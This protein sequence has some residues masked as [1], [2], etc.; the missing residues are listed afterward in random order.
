MRLDAL[1]AKYVADG[2]AAARAHQPRVDA[3]AY[4]F[5]EHLLL[6]NWPKD[7]GIQHIEAG[8]DFVMRFQQLTG[9]AMAKGMEDTTFYTY[10]RLLS[11]NEVGGNPGSFGVTLEQFHK[12]NAERLTKWRGSLLATAT[13]DTK[14]GEDVR[15]RLNVLSELPD[16]WKAAVS[17]WQELN[18]S[19]K[20]LV[21]GCKSPTAND[22]YFFYQTLVGTW[23]FEADKPEPNFTVRLYGHVFSMFEKFP[24]LSAAQ[25]RP[26]SGEHFDLACMAPLH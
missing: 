25:Q 23:P 19:C 2:L 13:H 6:L 12:A 5:I 24:M 21:S 11:L 1:G 10:N 8:Q 3:A 4:D 20:A 15:A 14:R 7:F 22:E 26:P 17:R 16:E 9:P 18:Q